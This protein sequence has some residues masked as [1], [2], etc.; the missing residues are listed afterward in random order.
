V[1]WKN[2]TIDKGIS[3]IIPIKEISISIILI[4]VFFTAQSLLGAK[5]KR[6]KI[7][8]KDA[9]SD[10][11]LYSWDNSKSNDW[12]TSA[13]QKVLNSGPYY[14]RTSGT[15]PHIT[16]DVSCN[17]SSTGL[18]STAKKMLGTSVYWYKGLLTLSRYTPAY[19]HQY[20][21]GDNASNKN[22]WT[23]F[24]GLMY[25]SDFGYAAGTKNCI[26]NVNLF[27]FSSKEDS[28]LCSSTSKNW[29]SNY[30]YLSGTHTLSEAGTTK[31]HTIDIWNASQPS[32]GV[33][34][35]IRRIYPSVYLSSSIKYSGGD[36][37]SSNP[38]TISL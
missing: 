23:G 36:G 16:G 1:F 6:V 38:Y 33:V 32:K 31:A 14:N 5:E 12:S 26:L 17:F 11:V 3:K 30:G 29:L 15:C 24:V 8:R 13:L 20:E 35:T 18:T 34:E 25:P 2:T 21:R 9:L 4:I 22:Y 27:D 28:N 37:S 10:G 19:I 7:I